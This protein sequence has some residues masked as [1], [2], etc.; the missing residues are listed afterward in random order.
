MNTIIEIPNSPIFARLEQR[1][2]GIY[3]TFFSKKGPCPAPPAKMKAQSWEQAQADVQEMLTGLR[4]IMST[5]IA[6]AVFGALAKRFG[7]Q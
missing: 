7:K 5:P 1:N 3:L 6:R 4:R 2:D